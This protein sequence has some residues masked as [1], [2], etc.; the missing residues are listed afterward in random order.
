MSMLRPLN[1]KLGHRI[2]IFCLPGAWTRLSAC[3][4]TLGKRRIFLM[5]QRHRLLEEAPTSIGF[6]TVAGKKRRASES[7]MD[8]STTKRVRETNYNFS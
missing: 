2:T 1:L 3:T 7:F 4:G 6:S 5:F 8:D